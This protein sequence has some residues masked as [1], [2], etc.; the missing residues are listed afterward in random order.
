MLQEGILLKCMQPHS[1]VDTDALLLIYHYCFFVSW[2]FCAN[3][4]N[5]H[6]FLIQL[7]FTCFH[8]Q[9]IVLCMFIQICAMSNSHLLLSLSLL[10]S[11]PISLPPYVAF[12]LYA[13]YCL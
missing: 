11:L 8:P 9:R 10:I 6:V 12:S 1:G 4:N 2:L 3:N 7:N 13:Y 5:L